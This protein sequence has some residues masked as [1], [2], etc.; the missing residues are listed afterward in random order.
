MIS[1]LMCGH[2]NLLFAESILVNLPSDIF[3]AAKFFILKWRP[4]GK[5]FFSN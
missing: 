2:F 5:D 3:P 4:I 1:S